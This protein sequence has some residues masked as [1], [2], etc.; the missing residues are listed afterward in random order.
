MKDN[1]FLDFSFAFGRPDA[2]ANFRT[3]HSDFIVREK[4]GFTPCGE[5]EHLY[6]HIKKSGENTSWVAGKLADYFAVKTMDVGYCGKKDRNADTTQWFSVYL[7]TVRHDANWE[8]FICSSGLNAQVVESGR[9]S[10]KL[11][12]GMHQSNQFFIRLRSVEN[13]KEALKRLQQI[14]SDGVPN[15]FGEQRFG[16]EASNLKLAG[17]WFDEGEKINNHSKRSLIMSAAR[18]YLFNLVLSKRVEEKSWRVVL[19]G[20][21]CSENGFVCGPLWGRGRSE[22]SANALAIETDVLQNFHSWCKRL[23]HLGLQQE[24]RSFVLLPQFMSW[25]VD[26]ADITVEFELAPGEFATSVLREVCLLAYPPVV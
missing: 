4:L 2:H 24:R 14:K 19:P 7:P 15:Y 22:S 20:D 1:Y 26:G 12:R 3:L 16:R 6:V 10:R 11:R 13:V 23:E 8:E 17:S 18:S 21:V 25:Q 5:G 9:H